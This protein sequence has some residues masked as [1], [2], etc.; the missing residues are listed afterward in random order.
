MINTKNKIISTTKAKITKIKVLWDE[1]DKGGEGDALVIG[2]VPG[3][4][5]V[6]CGCVVMVDNV[7]GCVE[8]VDAGE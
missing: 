6:K 8:V 4:L 2:N 7:D 5:E 3:W 1:G